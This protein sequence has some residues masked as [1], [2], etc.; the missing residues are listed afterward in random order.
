MRGIADVGKSLSSLLE[1]QP[2]CR[3]QAPHVSHNPIA[4][5]GHDLAGLACSR[6]ALLLWGETVGRAAHPEKGGNDFAAQ[7]EDDNGE[8]KQILTEQSPH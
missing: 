7:E 3:P 6:I 4:R 1:H 8:S 2:A 5:Q